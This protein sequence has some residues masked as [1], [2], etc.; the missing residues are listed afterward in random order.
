MPELLLLTLSAVTSAAAYLLGRRRGLSPR[1][2]AAAVAG[3]LEC[4][5]LT[6]LF[7]GSNLGLGILGIL[8]T[9]KLTGAFVSLYAVG[10]MMLLVLSLLQA[11]VFAWWRDRRAPEAG[12]ARRA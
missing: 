5:G 7:Y 6:V 2:L 1:A 11:L 12:S 4:L 10:D 9:R 8:A 3:A